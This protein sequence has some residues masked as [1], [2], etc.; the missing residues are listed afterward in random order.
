MRASRVLAGMTAAFLFLPAFLRA[1]PLKPEYFRRCAV[2]G[3]ARGGALYQ[4]P[5]GRDILDAC[6]PGCRDLRL[7]AED[8]RDVPFVII[9][10]AIPQASR[11]AYELKATGY[12]DDAGKAAIV[13]RMPD[14]FEPVGSM[15]LKTPDRDF[16]KTVVIYGS[17][18]GEEWERI[19]EDAVFDFSS[20]VDVRKTELTFPAA[21]FRYFRLVMG[22]ADPAAPAEAV[23][24]RYNGI[25]L[26]IN[27]LKNRRLRIDGAVAYTPFTE[28]GRVLYDEAPLSGYE[29]KTDKDGNSVLTFRTGLPFDRLRI[30]AEG[31]YYYRSV[32]ILQSASGKEGT[33]APLAASAVYKF[34][35]LKA[36][37]EKSVVDAA[38]AGSGHYRLVIEN[39]GNRPL[40][41]RGMYLSWVRK[42]LFF[43]PERDTASHRLCADSEGRGAGAPPYDLG[44][45]VTAT[46]WNRQ[47]FET[48]KASAAQENADYRP[49]PAGDRKARM[50]KT[51][52][53]AVVILLVIGLG[54]WLFALLRRADRP[55]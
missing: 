28:E 21:S 31:P 26:S 36:E 11:T 13:F 32:R 10:H 42:N 30:D 15:A 45:F 2:V 52:F 20:Q 38:R 40:R 47:A 37:E 33:Y 46:N 14:R 12:S 34:P 22:D 3:Q 24:L 16:R 8:G 51:V 6:G 27:S 1:E 49:A 7:F 55:R 53:T 19:A 9:D 48:L 5:L 25:D 4:V 54:Y 18:D 41:L 43:V 39:G 17:Q 44:R 35:F 50:E 23:R 29:E